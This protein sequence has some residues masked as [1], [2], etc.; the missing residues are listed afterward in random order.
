MPMMSGYEVPKFTTHWLEIEDRNRTVQ[1]V[2]IIDADHTLNQVK[3]Q[4]FH[5][6]DLNYNINLQK[7]VK[8]CL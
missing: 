1:L 2:H 7:Q 6:I 8:L 5:V 4:L 3:K